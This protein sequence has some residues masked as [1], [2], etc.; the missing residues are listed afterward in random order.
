[1]PVVPALPEVPAEP[2]VPAT[3]VVPA[4]P[5]PAP[6]LVPAAPSSELPEQPIGASAR[7]SPSATATNPNT[8][9]DP[10]EVVIKLVSLVVMEGA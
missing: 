1:V 6:P 4:A 8:R 7:P 9:A 5:V 10:V 3:P 2:V